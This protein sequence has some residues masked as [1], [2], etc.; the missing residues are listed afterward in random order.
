MGGQQWQVNDTPKSFEIATA[1]VK[2][3]TSGKSG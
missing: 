2:K 1:K 3:I